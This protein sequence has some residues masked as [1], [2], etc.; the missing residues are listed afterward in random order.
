MKIS[1]VKLGKTNCKMVIEDT[2]PYFVNSLRRVILSEIPKL[3]VSYVTI[4]DNTSALFDEIIAQ[5]IGMIPL[6]TRL[7]LLGFKEDCACEGK[8]CPNC[9][10]LY[11]L[12]KEGPCTVY[13]SDLQPQDKSWAPVDGNI[14]IIKLTEGQRIILEAEANL[15]RGKDHAKWQ[16]A[17]GVGY[18]YFPII[19]IDEKKCNL[20]NK[21]VEACPKKI[22]EIKNKK[23]TIKDIEECTLCKSCVENCDQDAIKVRGDETKFIFKFETDGSLS[24]KEVL[25]EALEILSN[26]YKEIYKQVSKIK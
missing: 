2:T 12:S 15:G 26:R 14:P 13:S 16:V 7:D 24:A 21:C 3:A 11:T 6:P 20:C 8:G 5:R 17:H 22:L 4:Y 19:E 10:V 23:L 25:E 18:K 1:D 9:T